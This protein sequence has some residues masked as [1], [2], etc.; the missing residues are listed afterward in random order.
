MHIVRLDD[1]KIGRQSRQIEAGTAAAGRGENRAA[2]GALSEGERASQTFFAG[3]NPEVET[4]HVSI[5]HIDSAAAVVDD[6][7]PQTAQLDGGSKR[8][9]RRCGNHAGIHGRAISASNPLP[10]HALIE[11][12]AT[13]DVAAL[14]RQR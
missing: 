3:T 4:V 9:G 6:N 5:K 10:V 12:F 1:G 13:H 14:T 7:R 8:I 2:Y 11:E